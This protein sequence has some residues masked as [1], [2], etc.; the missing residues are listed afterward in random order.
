[1]RIRSRNVSPKNSTVKIC[2]SQTVALIRTTKIR[3]ACCLYQKQYQEI[4]IIHTGLYHNI[5]TAPSVAVIMCDKQR[6]CS[7]LTSSAAVWCTARIRARYQLPSSYL[8]T[9]NSPGSGLRIFFGL[10]RPCEE[11]V[12]CCAIGGEIQSNTVTTQNIFIN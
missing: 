4:F 6:R 12:C 10:P 1:M 5:L 3:T 8:A 7:G 9:Q 11:Q 2:P